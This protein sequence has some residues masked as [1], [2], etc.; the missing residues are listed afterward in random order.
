MGPLI[1]AKDVTLRYGG[2]MGAVAAQGI[3]FEVFPSERLIILGP[4]GCGKSSILKAVAGYLAPAEGSVKFGSRVVTGPSSDRILVFQE[5]EQLFPWKTVK[6]NIVFALEASGRSRGDGARRAADHWLQK[7]GL[8]GFSDSFPHTLSIGMRQRA[9]VARALALQP[10]T[11]IMD[12]PFAALDAFTRESLQM[13]LRALWEEL[14]FTLIFVT[15]SIEEAIFL[16]SRILVLS[17][18]PGRIRAT[19]DCTGTDRIDP[20]T[21]E[22]LSAIIKKL[23]FSE[24][25]EPPAH[26]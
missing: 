17:P 16:G 15:H 23:I 22:S 10:D 19:F 5:T 8:A 7:V 6:Q 1:E 9:A 2:P 3:N 20:V 21:G 26:V 13:E 11:L 18:H 25:G 4:S 12:E 24:M 14:R